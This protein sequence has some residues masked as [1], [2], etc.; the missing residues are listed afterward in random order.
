MQEGVRDKGTADTQNML[1]IAKSSPGDD[2]QQRQEPG[3][4]RGREG[5]REGA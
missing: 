2:E 3:P 5:E 4:R 1:E